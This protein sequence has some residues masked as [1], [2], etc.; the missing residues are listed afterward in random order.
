MKFTKKPVTIEAHQWDGQN[1]EE[2]RAFAPGKFRML[3]KAE[4]ILEYGSEEYTA[5]VYDELHDTWVGMKNTNWVIK[6]VKG[7]FYPIDNDVL[8]ETY[9][10]ANFQ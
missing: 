2:M 8:W 3:S 7:E 6:G 4:A 1:Y 5:E 9:D 10:V